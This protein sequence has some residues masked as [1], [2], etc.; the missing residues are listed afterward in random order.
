MGAI[1]Y[2]LVVSGAAPAEDDA[3]A[4]VEREVEYRDRAPVDRTPVDRGADYDREYRDRGDYRDYR[5]DYR[6][7]RY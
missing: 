6:D 7:D 5:E 2:R 1:I 4:R 3:P